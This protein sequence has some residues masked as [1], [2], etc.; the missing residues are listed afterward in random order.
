MGLPV[1]GW[2]LMSLIWLSRMKERNEPLE[3]GP[4]VRNV[5]GKLSTKRLRLPP[6]SALGEANTGSVSLVSHVRSAGRLA[7]HTQDPFN[8]RKSTCPFDFIVH[9]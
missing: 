9:V 1:L 5:S 3:S 6:G 4:T 8:S 7:A 2:K